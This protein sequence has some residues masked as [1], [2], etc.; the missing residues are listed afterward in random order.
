MS[1]SHAADRARVRFIAEML[2][3]HSNARAAASSQPDAGFERPEQ[4]VERMTSALRK[5]ALGIA[6]LLP[7]FLCSPVHSQSWRLDRSTFDTSAEACSDFYQYV[8]GG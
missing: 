4:G 7:L 3:R 6:A 5:G 2:V 8:C 1:E